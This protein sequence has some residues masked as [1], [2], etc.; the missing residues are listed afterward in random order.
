MELVPQAP[1]R[2]SNIAAL[3]S[4]T[5]L[6]SLN[7]EELDTLAQA[8]H[9]AYAERGETIWLHGRQ[10]DF[11]GLVGAGF[12]KM[13]RSLETGQEVTTEIIGPGQIFGLLGTIEGTGCPQTARAVCNTWYLKIPKSV[14]M[15]IYHEQHI[16][17]E[18]LLRRTTQR[19]RSNID[20]LAK[21]STGKVDERIAVILSLLA[22]SYGNETPSGLQIQIPL[23]RQD[24]AE[25]AGTTVESTIR[26]MS[27]WQKDGLI[28]SDH[29]FITILDTKAFD[30]LLRT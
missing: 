9:M 6:N 11:Y 3:R 25:M 10:V 12:V 28:E 18:H 14:F 21:M 15:P 23:T 26:V 24:I 16:L 19:F 7:T 20:L 1:E 2:P 13:V 17:K 27:R 8:S 30:E 4:S 29:R 5:L 22:Q